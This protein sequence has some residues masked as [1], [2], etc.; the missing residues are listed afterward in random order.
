VKEVQRYSYYIE[1]QVNALQRRERR[2]REVVQG[3][4]E[5]PLLLLVPRDCVRML[6]AAESG[7]E[8]AVA[9][10]L[11]QGSDTT[12]MDSGNHT[13]LHLAARGGHLDIVALLQT[14]CPALIEAVDYSYDTALHLA[15]RNGH[16]EIMK[17]LLTH[18]AR[19]NVSTSRTFP[20]TALHRAA[21]GGHVSV[22]RQ[23]LAHAPML[24]D[25]R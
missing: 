21:E 4:C 1:E 16:D 19:V 12:V 8:E 18:G 11:A 24:I 5:R 20:R 15:A 6:H 10:L 22:V 7:D 2:F 13:A 23:L 9:R 17:L 3:E 25:V 14:H